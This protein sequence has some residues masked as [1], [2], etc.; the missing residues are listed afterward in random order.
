M[1]QTFFS[2]TTDMGTELGLAG[3]RGRVRDYLPSW[4]QPSAPCGATGTAAAA[5]DPTEAEWCLDATQQ[6]QSGRGGGAPQA[7]VSRAAPG[8]R[9]L[10]SRSPSPQPVPVPPVRPP[11]P[12]PRRRPQYF[13]RQG[14]GARCGLHALNN[15]VG[16]RLFTVEDLSAATD[17]VLLEL[18]LPPYEGGPLLELPL[19]EDHETATGWYSEQVLATALLASFRYAFN[20]TSLAHPPERRALL[21]DPALAGALVNDPGRHWM[22]LRVLLG[23][24]W[25]LDS[26]EPEP[27]RLGPIRGEAFAHFANRYPRIFPVYELGAVDRLVPDAADAHAADSPTPPAVPEPAPAPV[28]QADDKS[29][30]GPTKSALAVRSVGGSP[31]PRV[32]PVAL[33][34]S[35]ML[36]ILDN[37]THDLHAAL[38]H[39]SVLRGQIRVLAA[40]LCDRSRRELFV[41]SCLRKSPFRSCES[42]FLKGARLKKPYDKRW[43][44]TAEFMKQALPW[45][46]ML[47]CAWGPTT[48]KKA[49]A[50]RGDAEADVPDGWHADEFDEAEFSK[51]LR[52]SLFEAYVRV[53]L[54]VENVVTGLRQWSESCPC[55]YLPAS[56]PDARRRRVHA[57]GITQNCAMA[58][59]RAPEMAVGRLAA[60]FPEL[61]DIAFGEVL[62][63]ARLVLSKEDLALLAADLEHARAHFETVLRAKLSFWNELPWKLAGLASHDP[64]AVQ[65]T[66]RHAIESFDATPLALQ[67]MHHPLT[68]RFLG[69]AEGNV[70]RGHVAALAEGTRLDELPHHFQAAVAAFSFIPIV[71]RVI[72]GRHKDVKFALGIAKAAGPAEISATLRHPALLQQ[73]QFLPGFR[74]ELLLELRGIR[75]GQHGWPIVEALGWESHP[76]LAALRRTSQRPG[77]WP[78]A[79]ATKAL[80]RILYRCDVDAQFHSHAAAAQANRAAAASEKAEAAEVTQTHATRGRPGPLHSPGSPESI[81]LRGAA[82]HMLQLA[83]RSE[84]VVFSLASSAGGVAMMQLRDVLLGHGG[85]GAPREATEELAQDL[86]VDSWGCDP[87]HRC[88]FQVLRCSVHRL[89]RTPTAGA[90][91]NH[92]SPWQL[93]VLPLTFLHGVPGCSAG[94]RRP[95]VGAMPCVGDSSRV[96][97][98]AIPETISLETL[99][100]TLLQWR[101]SRHLTYSLRHFRSQVASPSVLAELLEQFMSH[102]GAVPCLGSGSVDEDGKTIACASRSARAALLPVLTSSLNCRSGALPPPAR[103]AGNSPMTRFSVSKVGSLWKARERF[104]PPPIAQCR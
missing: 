26:L 31:A 86:S 81:L 89:K 48:F 20:P 19:R 40:F 49:T 73:L 3:L 101:R 63:D 52:S 4:L 91:P 99:S 46:P 93:A 102:V 17:H 60:V 32:F 7:T 38:R 36:H 72:E 67:H 5:K 33:A 27:R 59:K 79:S 21:A 87:D 92:L 80:R 77:A 9:V 10:R 58:G 71:E 96:H 53:I 85:G 97:M 11:S 74:E 6:H 51:V 94:V 75:F 83:R 13:E 100:A 98:L 41:A 22:A 39:W 62:V 25:L 82:D 44:S 55:H 34:V 66:A 24:V 35:G 68:L 18:S 78:A 29:G 84:Q 37:L 2:F 30:V 61:A 54:A 57:L 47:R 69:S 8:A 23:D 50:R 28:E 42:R 95:V 56:L 64:L 15:C 70:F 1:A 88:F 103:E 76:A 43:G 104:C 45:L 90:V 16:R 14:A 65:D 12:R